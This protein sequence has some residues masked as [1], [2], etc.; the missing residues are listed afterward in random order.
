Y[1]SMT[2]SSLWTGA[3]TRFF[4]LALRRSFAARSND[5]PFSAFCP[6][7]LIGNQDGSSNRNRGIGTDQNADYQ[8]K[9]ETVQDLT[10]E[11]VESEHSQDC[12][13]RRQDGPAQ[14]LVNAAI[15]DVRQL[16]TPHQFDVL[17]DAIEDHNGVVVRIAN[18]SQDCCDDRQ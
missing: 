3:W 11:E 10:S 16:L 7:I 18:Q 6:P 1:F 5:W 14:C 2:Y 17:A 4:R 13:P 9:R 8:S 15:D 12:K